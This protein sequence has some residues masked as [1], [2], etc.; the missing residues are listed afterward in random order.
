MQKQIGKKAR[1]VCSKDVTD[2]DSLWH[3]DSDGK[4]WCGDWYHRTPKQ[5]KTGGGVGA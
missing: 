1:K 3:S 4:F 2:T 5:L